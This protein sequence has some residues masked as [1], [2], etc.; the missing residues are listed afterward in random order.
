MT[1]MHAKPMPPLM[2]PLPASLS[3]RR[4]LSA[5]AVLGIGSGARVEA[6]AQEARLPVAQS[7][8]DELKAAL[9][10]R[11]PLIVMASL[12]G[13]IYCLSARRS[14]LL[15]LWRGGQA[16]VQLDL[17]SPAAVRDF[18]GHVTTHDEL[19]RRW[20][21]TVTPTLLFIGP[22]GVELAERM[23]GGYQPDF[24]GPY[25]AQRLESAVRRL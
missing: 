24:Y 6:H 18:S 10:R 17:R 7:L 21:I 19:S 15:P 16:I 14:H 13:C 22:G 11:Q 1:P 9:A 25:L 2:D 12:E 5:C 8:P 3:R 20:N 4:W 23:E